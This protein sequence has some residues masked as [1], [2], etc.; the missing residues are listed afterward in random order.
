MPI[1]VSTTFE[2][3]IAATPEA[4]WEVMSDPAWQERLESRFRLESTTGESGTVGSSYDGV[5]RRRRFRTVVI[6]AEPWV[7]FGVE[8]WVRSARVG[9]QHG[10]LLR[11]GTDIVLRWTVVARTPRLLRGVVAASARRE[12]PRWLDNVARE[13]EALAP[14]R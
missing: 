12:V 9:E 6:V 7:R 11:D 14:S 13:A 3:R 10:E 1:D 5:V 8:A 2:R 4:V